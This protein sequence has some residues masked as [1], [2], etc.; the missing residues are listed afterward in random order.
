MQHDNSDDPFGFWNDEPTRQLK[1]THV[2]A[3]SHAETRMVP[4]VSADRTRPVTALHRPRNPLL[5]RIALMGGVTV[6]LV[7]FALSLR[8]DNPP[9]VR[10]AEIQAVDT[11]QVG[12]LPQPAPTVATLTP[13]TTAA[14][15]TIAE[16]TAAEVTPAPTEAIVNTPAP[17]APTTT[18]PKVTKR[19]ATTT[20]PAPA[21]AATQAADRSCAMTYTIVKG[22]AWSSIASRATVSMKSLLAANGATVNTLLLPGKSICLPTGAVVPGPAATNP[23]A[24]KAPAT[25][26]PPTTQPK[27]PAPTTPPPATSPPSTQPPAPPNVYTKAQAAQIIRDVW[28]DD[29]EDEAIR[30]ATRES[31]LIPTVHNS[32]CYGLFQIYYTA[33]KAWLA[34]MGITSAAQLYDPQVNAT[35]AYALYRNSGWAPWATSSPTT[36]TVA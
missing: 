30:I 31:N 8:K 13:N 28:P 35:A 3:R 25:T 12:V 1:R 24:V 26:Q 23:P 36:T 10:A 6:L 2:G 29:L 22:D 7:P 9:T 5:T 11:I 14:P 21:A 19:A 4:V 34:S 16:T 20:T 27:A 32:C 18:A 15:T 17:T 33:H